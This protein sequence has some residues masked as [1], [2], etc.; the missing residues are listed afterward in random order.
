M[1]DF[2]AILWLESRWM[3]SS[4][5]GVIHFEKKFWF[6]HHK[7]KCICQHCQRYLSK[8]LNVF[9]RIEKRVKTSATCS[10]GRCHQ[11]E[12]EASQRKQ[13]QNEAKEGNREDNI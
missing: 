8:L 13:D 3:A 1:L 10:S 9:L 6:G 2:L 4:S 5:A 12:E 11:L 7:V